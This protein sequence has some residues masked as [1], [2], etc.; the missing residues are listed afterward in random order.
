MG[1]CLLQSKTMS[2]VVSDEKSSLIILFMTQN[3]RGK[4]GNEMIYRMDSLLFT[5][6]Y[7][8]TEKR[9][10]VFSKSLK[11]EKNRILASLPSLALCFQPRSRLFVGL[12]YTKIRTVLQSTIFLP[13]GLVS[14]YNCK[15]TFFLSV[16]TG[17]QRSKVSFLEIILENLCL[18][19]GT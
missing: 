13:R 16:L 18:Y 7:F 17:S 4:K 1:N 15:F 11:G 5:L 12:E 19:S 3:V 6:P 9:S 10:V 2:E 8:Q 14:S